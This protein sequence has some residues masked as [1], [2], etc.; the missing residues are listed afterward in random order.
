MQ[1]ANL[2][3][4]AAGK[5][6][7]QSDLARLAGVSRQAVSLWFRQAGQRDGFVDIKT[8]HLERLAAG[9]HVRADDLLRPLPAFGPT[10]REQMAAKYLWDRLYP[11]L[12]E[13]LVA[14]A[15]GERR[16]LARLVDREGLFAAAK[17]AGAPVWEEFQ[18]YK[19]YLPSA[20]RR[21]MER[22]WSLQQHQA[23]T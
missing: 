14:L 16:A 23:P 18:A 7:T 21:A 5:R 6:L 2:A 22:L 11:S 12:E 4:V 13:F 9:L 10:E 3:L 15:A 17:I 8:R 19:A 1:M 20:R